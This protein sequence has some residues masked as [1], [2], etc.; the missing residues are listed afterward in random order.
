MAIIPRK[1]RR[2]R[3]TPYFIS[4]HSIHAENI[5]NTA[6]RRKKDNNIVEGLEKNLADSLELDKTVYLN[7]FAGLTL[8]EVFQN[9]KS[10]LRISELPTKMKFVGNSISGLLKNANAFNPHF[11]SVFKEDTS[12]LSVPL[13]SEDTTICLEDMY[14]TSSEVES[15]ILSCHSGSESYDKMQPILLKT[16][17]TAIVPVVTEIFK[18]I[19]KHHEFPKSWKKAIIK[20]LHKK[21]SR[22]DIQYYRPV[23]MLCA[24]SLI[25]ENLLY[26]KFRVLLLKNLDNRQHG[27]RPHLSTI[28]QMLQNCGK[29]F[30]CL[31]AKESALSIYL[32]TAKALNTINHNAIFLHIIY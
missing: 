27:F 7:S 16:F 1:T 12:R 13:N 19:I 29:L 4:S 28:T 21:G 26:R 30:L 10:F 15:M 20:L 17:S 5:L 25:F 23:S 18:K 22:I 24:L 14:F 11:A 31:N 8:T 6:R 9:I 32:H 3:E 2:R